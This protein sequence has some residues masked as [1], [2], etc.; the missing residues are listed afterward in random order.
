MLPQKFCGIK[1]NTEAATDVM[2]RAVVVQAF[3]RIY[4]LFS[5]VMRFIFF[6]VVT[7]LVRTKLSVCVSEKR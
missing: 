5:Y 4:K 7:L 6:S 3:L 1:I 2:E